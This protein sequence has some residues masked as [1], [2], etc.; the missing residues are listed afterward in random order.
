MTSDRR[1]ALELWA[2]AFIQIGLP[3]TTTRTAFAGLMALPQTQSVANELKRDH[4][5][6]A[7][8]LRDA[9]TSHR[10]SLRK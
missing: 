1:R 7:A 9:A 10:A 4:P 8:R 2:E 3:T 6:L 5:D